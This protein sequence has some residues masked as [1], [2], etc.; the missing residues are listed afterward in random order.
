M[1]MLRQQKR[2]QPSSGSRW[3]GGD[4]I[5][6]KEVEEITSELSTQARMTQPPPKTYAIALFEHGSAN[7]H[8]MVLVSRNCSGIR[9]ARQPFDQKGSIG[10]GRFCRIV[11]IN[12]E[13]TLAI[14][15]T[16]L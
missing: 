9:V 13:C 8:E 2:V 10:K 4:G 14:D 7:L 11:F 12:I 1:A 6:L 5:T 16:L 3:Y 15:L